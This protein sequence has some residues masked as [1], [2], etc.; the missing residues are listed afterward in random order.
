[1]FKITFFGFQNTMNKIVLLAFLCCWLLLTPSVIQAEPYGLYEGNIADWNTESEKAR[2]LIIRA[3][4]QYLV[5][6]EVVPRDKPILE[7]FTT[8]LH[9][10]VSSIAASERLPLQTSIHEI[11]E[12]CTMVLM[13]P[14]PSNP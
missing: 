5:Q 1:M 3:F 14:P 2:L 4:A 6:K 12:S 13:T 10:C 8:T 11:V 9:Q 7:Q